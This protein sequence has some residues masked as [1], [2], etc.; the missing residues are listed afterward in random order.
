MRLTDRE[1]FGIDTLLPTDPHQLDSYCDQLTLPNLDR[2]DSLRASSPLALHRA[3]VHDEWLKSIGPMPENGMLSAKTVARCKAGNLDIETIALETMPDYFVSATLFKPQTEEAP[4]PAVL[5]VCGHNREG[6]L[7]P[8]YQRAAS[9]IASVKVFHVPISFHSPM[10]G[11][12]RMLLSC[13]A[14]A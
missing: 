7:A 13:S 8:A 10:Y 12:T 9:L 3:Y 2:G 1:H 11:R 5:F 6:R 14:T 4:L